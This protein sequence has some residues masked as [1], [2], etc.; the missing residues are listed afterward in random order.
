MKKHAKNSKLQLHKDTSGAA[1]L[2][3]IVISMV[4]VLLSAT[5]MLAGYS[6]YRSVLN[7][8]NDFRCRELA[9][10]IANTLEEEL[11]V[12]FDTYEEQ[13]SARGRGEHALWFYIRDHIWQKQQNV[14]TDWFYFSDN[15]NEQRL[16]HTIKNSKRYFSLSGD[17]AV[18]SNAADDI[19]ITLYWK[20]SKADYLVGIL[21]SD[22]TC[23]YVQ[24]DVKRL[25]SSYSVTRAY[26][27]TVLGDASYIANGIES[28]DPEKKREDYY[29]WVWKSY[30]Y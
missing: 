6:L 25:N 19:R 1:M 21:D 10:T 30:E 14:N 12:T 13:E 22:E 15:T 26:Q 8:N 3:A 17:A 4:F 27:L 9:Q 11:F 18:L 20:S 28:I 24:V 29:K 2:I 16:G 5:L 7:D 23:L